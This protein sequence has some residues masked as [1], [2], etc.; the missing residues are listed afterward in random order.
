M[1][2][3]RAPKDG[4]GPEQALDVG[5]RVEQEMRLRLGP[6]HLQARLDDPRF[7]LM[8]RESGTRL[9]NACRK[10]GPPWPDTTARFPVSSIGFFSG[11]LVAGRVRPS[12][13]LP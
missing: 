9:R 7:E 4:I 10:S 13:L 5:Q 12:P 3:H 11:M 2:E 1:V 6:H 8:A